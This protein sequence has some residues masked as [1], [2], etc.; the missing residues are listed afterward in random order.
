MIV[1]EQITGDEFRILV[2]FGKVILAINRIP[3]HVIGNGTDTIKKLIEDENASNPLRGNG[4]DNPIAYIPIDTEMKGYI[5]KQCYNLE[6]ILEEGKKLQLRG[7]SNTGTGGTIQDYTHLIHPEIQEICA[8]VA[9]LFQ[10]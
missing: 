10:F 4:Y 3:A 7:N 1:Q 8:K 5:A 9:E 2:L 6:S